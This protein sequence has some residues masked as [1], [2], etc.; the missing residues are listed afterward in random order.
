LESALT[1][2]DY[3][4][5]L[6]WHAL[7]DR[8]DPF[9]QITAIG[10]KIKDFGPSQFADEEKKAWGYAFPLIASFQ[11]KTALSFLAENGGSVGLMQAAHLALVFSVAGVD[12]SDMVDYPD[13]KSG[14]G[15]LTTILLTKYAQLLEREPSAGVLAALQYLLKI[16]STEDSFDKIASL[17]CRSPESSVLT[18]ELDPTFERTNSELDKHLSRKDV[19]VILTK[20]ASMLQ[21]QAAND[22]NTGKVCANLLML[23]SS[24]T[25]L[26]QLLCGLISPPN[27]TNDDKAY[28]AKESEFFYESYLSKHTIVLESLERDRK[29]GLVSTIRILLELRRFFDLHRNGKSEEAFNFLTGVRLLPLRQEEVNERQSIFRD[30]DPIVKQA[31]PDMIVAS[32][33]CLFHMY[34]RIKSECRVVTSEAEARLRELGHFARLIFTFAGLINMPSTCKNSVAQIRASMV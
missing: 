20:S 31:F 19:S 22:S 21:N 34:Q 12:V 2:E 18:G 30:L 14:G 7:Q 1:I 8:D 27:V 4:F 32:V 10:A 25:K 11:F 3:L 17:I 24:H 26:V 5:G 29:Q 6:F 9:S 13:N 16:P 15:D 28:W 33:E 23:A